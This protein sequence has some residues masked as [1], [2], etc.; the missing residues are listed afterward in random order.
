MCKLHTEYP[1][2]I[3]DRKTKYRELSIKEPVAL[4]EVGLE[5]LGGRP[6]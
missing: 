6:E 1:I 5:R 3:Q 2:V 4:V